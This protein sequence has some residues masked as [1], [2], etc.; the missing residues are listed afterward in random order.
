MTRR[1]PHWYTVVLLCGAAVF[2]SYIDRTNMSV[3][4]IA[5]KEQFGWT[6]TTKGVVLSSFFVG[7]LLLQVVSGTL[8]NRYGGKI[9]LGIAVVWWSAVRACSTKMA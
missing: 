9:V 7:Y 3:A 2:I 6:E 8:A 4:A 1:W 5:M